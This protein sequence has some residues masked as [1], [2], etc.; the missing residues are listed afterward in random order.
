MA[1]VSRIFL[2]WSRASC[3]DDAAVQ[4][5]GAAGGDLEAVVTVVGSFLKESQT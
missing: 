1:A 4:V 5:G 2:F 3:D